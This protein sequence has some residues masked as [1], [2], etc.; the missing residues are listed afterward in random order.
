[1]KNEQSYLFKP[2]VIS[3]K[4]TSGR[5]PLFIIKICLFYSSSLRFSIEISIS[6]FPQFIF[7]GLYLIFK[8]VF[9]NLIIRK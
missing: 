1:M 6:G 4:S 9:V 7:C 5:C 3:I 2:N 8:Q